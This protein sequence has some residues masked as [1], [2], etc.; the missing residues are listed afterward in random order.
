MIDQW[1]K[2]D[3]QNI[4]DKHDVAVFIDESGDAEFLLKCC[5]E[6]CSIYQANSEIE[7]LHVKYQI[8]KMRSADQK[9]LIYSRTSKEDLKF[10]REYCETDGCV[11]IRYLQNYIKEKVHQTLNL[12]INLAKEELI[13][14]AKVSVGKD[15]SYWQDISHKGAS[16]IFD[17][18]IELLSFLHD[19][20]KYNAERFDQQLRETFYRKVHELIGQQYVARKPQALASEVVGKM[21]ENLILNR[22]SEI[23]DHVYAGWLDSMSYKS[24]FQP[25]LTKYKLPH[26][27]KPWT[28]SIDHPFRQ[29][30]ECWLKEIGANLYEK[31]KMHEYLGKITARHESKKAR[32]AGINFWGDVKTL[33][34]FDSKN[35]SYLSSLD[36]VI[37]FYKLHFCKIDNA[38]RRLYS[39]FLNSRDLIEP[40]QE[41]YKEQVTILLDRWF[42]YFNCYEQN[43]TGTIQKIIDE[44]ADKIAII[45]GDGVAYEVAEEIAAGVQPSIKLTRNHI[46]ADFPSETENNMSHI[47][48]DDGTTRKMQM[49]RVKYLTEKN[50]EKSLEFIDLD[51]FDGEEKAAQ[52]LICTHK[53]FDAMGEK[54]QHKALKYFP[55]TISSMAGK[56]VSLL[57]A[58][59]KKVYLISDHGFVLSGL[60]CE[61][62]KIKV[63]IRG[64][65]QKA[66]RYIL[67]NEEQSEFS[68]SF[69]EIKKKH[70]TF[71]Y[72]YFSNT[73][74]PFKT[75]GPYGY[76]HGGLSPQELITPYFCWEL[77]DNHDSKLPVKISNKSDLAAV[78]GEIYQVKFIAGD[79]PGDLLS[80]N[81]KIYL[82][83]F[84][85]GKQVNKSD[86]LTISKN[87]EV[88]KEYSFDGAKEIEVQLLDAETKECLDR[89]KIK[90]DS[91]RDLGGLL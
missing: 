21:F 52:Y 82:V 41:L 29:I 9:H 68:E 72:L 55:E 6:N 22:K 91:V 4:Y 56:I 83:F 67:A 60:L 85:N 61:A 76:S 66:E 7:E 88:C 42:K 69:I 51:T 40:L 57:Q 62:D 2:K 84:E 5:A 36:E 18:E 74:N 8:E 90:R 65:A 16:E 87:E 47:Y 30:D 71:N 54:F 79:I 89:I 1:F 10:I 64:V 25:Y 34:E 75:P 43:Q 19:P 39:V 81:R 3:L 70:G 28:V 80:Q 37:D 14:A 31:E 44:N 17:L 46:L 48:I 86:L 53:D 49:D 15:R 35:I 24:S 38:I 20:V 50:S 32:A 45:V 73:L 33:I 12:N 59:Y 63:D 77:S 26:D 23:L 78:A 11:E 13:A 58:G 27:F